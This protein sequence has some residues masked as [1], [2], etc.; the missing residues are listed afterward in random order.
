MIDLVIDAGPLP[1]RPTST[2]VRLA[3]DRIKV[4]RHGAFG[5]R[6]LFQKESQS[7]LRTKKLAQAIFHQFLA[8][9]LVGKAVT[10]IMRGGL[11]A[12]KT[13]FAQGDSLHL[14]GAGQ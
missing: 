7:E 3:G 4:L 9:E 10:V 12:G 1:R 11:G 5:L 2:V 6:L 14:R 13:V 8:K